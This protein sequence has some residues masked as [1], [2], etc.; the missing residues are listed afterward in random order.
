MF[1]GGGGGA[2][3]SGGAGGGGGGGD[4]DGD[5]LGDAT[6]DGL[7]DA[8]G[9]GLGDGECAVVGVLVVVSWA[10]CWPPVLG[11]DGWVTPMRIRISSTRPAQANPASHLVDERKSG[12]RFRSPHALLAKRTTA[13]APRPIAIP[14]RD[15][16]VK[17]AAMNRT[18]SRYPTTARAIFH[19]V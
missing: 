12:R 10:T 18:M 17:P 13:S 2:G 3:G 11:V 1:G 6:G 4:G 5:G 7:G 8:S 14:P 9:D 19:G 15:S 16:G